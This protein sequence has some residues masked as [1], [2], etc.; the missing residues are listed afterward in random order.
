MRALG[1][2][3]QR[4]LSLDRSI[5]AWRHLTTSGGIADSAARPCVEELEWLRDRLE[6][7]VPY[8]RA[9]IRPGFDEPDAVKGLLAAERA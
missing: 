2:T 9:F 1:R 6:A 4:A 5:Q 8:A 7:A 3:R